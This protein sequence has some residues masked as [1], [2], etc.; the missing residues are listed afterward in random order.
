VLINPI[1]PLQRGQFQRVEG[2]LY[3]HKEGA[4]G[5]PV[6]MRFQPGELRL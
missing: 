4:S 2:C 3:R 1:A 6:A 5:V